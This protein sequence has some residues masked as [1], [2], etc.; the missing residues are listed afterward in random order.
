MKKYLSL[1][2]LFISVVSYAQKKNNYVDSI[3]AYHNNYVL[4]HEVVK[5]SSRKF[6]R[7][8]APDKNYKLQCAFEQSADSSIISM[9]TSGKTI[10]QKDFIVY[11][12]ISFIIHDT[13]CRLNLYRSVIAKAPYQNY[14]FLPF[15]DLTTA[16]DTYGSGRYI[17][18]LTTAIKKNTVE[19]DFNK[20]Y[21]PYCAYTIG[22]NCPVPPKENFVPVAIKAGEKTFAKSLVH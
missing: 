8:Y 20:A 1:A 15:T 13:L 2:V 9:R 17:D 22:Y 4:S 5:G 21:N 7:F 19:I 16:Y 12:T 18:I 6:F 11:G 14:L 10:P 3:N